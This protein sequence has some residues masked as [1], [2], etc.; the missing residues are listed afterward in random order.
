V[1]VPLGIHPDPTAYD[2]IVRLGKTSAKFDRRTLQ[3]SKYRALP[4]VPKEVSWMAKLSNLGM[5]LNS[6]IGDCTI[7][8]AGHMI[9]Q[10]T[11]YALGA[12]VIPSDASI[13]KGY[14]D[15]G[16]YVPGDPST[17][18]GC[19]MLDVLNYWR[20][21]GIDGHNIYAFVQVNPRNLDEV[22]EAIYLFGNVYV[23]V[24]LPVSVQGADR[25]TVS[26]GPDAEPGS[27]GGHCIPAVAMSPETVT[28]ITWG[29]ILKMS[30]N[31]LTGY[32]DEMYAVLSTDWIGKIGTAP[33][34]FNLT[35]LDQDLAAL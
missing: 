17:D 1:P 34:G 26:S 13:L 12:A 28:V 16:G 2:S 15:V 27:W 8:A 31:F 22:R 19:A 29:S 5:M 30:H 20:K 14:E 25:W 9:Q 23:G 11:T 24:Q 7:A 35:M 3:F 32:C 33:S 21:T 4:P 6:D 18:N 10:W